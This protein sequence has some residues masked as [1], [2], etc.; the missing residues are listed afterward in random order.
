[1]LSGQAVA[2]VEGGFDPATVALVLAVVAVGGPVKGL[3]GFGYAVASTAVSAVL[4]APPVAVTLMKSRRLPAA[5][6]HRVGC[7][8]CVA[9]RW[10]HSANRGF[11]GRRATA[12]GGPLLALHADGT[13]TDE[14]SSEHPL[15]A[16]ANALVRAG[17]TRE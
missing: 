14:C 10:L 8:G 4:L 15:P 17:R 13:R 6:C 1:V 12:P 9:P 7:K 3:V 5:R 16:R 2:G 11:T